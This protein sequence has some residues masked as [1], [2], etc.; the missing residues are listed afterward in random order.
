MSTIDEKAQYEVSGNAASS[1]DHKDAADIVHTR[2]NAIG[3]AADLYGDIETAQEYG[4]VKR[5]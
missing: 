2:G 5:G 4:Y 1:Y 3:E